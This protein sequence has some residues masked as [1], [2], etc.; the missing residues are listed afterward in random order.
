VESDNEHFLFSF[1]VTQPAKMLA[2]PRQKRPT[3]GGGGEIS[4]VRPPPTPTGLTPTVRQP[5]SPAGTC[6]RNRRCDKTETCNS[7]PN[8]CKRY[9]NVCGDGICVGNLE[10]CVTCPQDC[11]SRRNETSGELEVC[12]GRR[13]TGLFTSDRCG[14]S[15]CDLGPRQC[16]EEACE[17]GSASNF[18][19]GWPMFVMTISVVGQAMYAVFL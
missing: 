1:L 11:A 19:L 15:I 16:V 4:P 14:N 13:G 9:N 5:T 12:C 18:G 17:T 2:E 3:G 6:N 8:D 10:D 7:C